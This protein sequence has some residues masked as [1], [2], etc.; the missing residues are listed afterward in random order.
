[1]HEGL[2]FEGLEVTLSGIIYIHSI[3]DDRMT[4]T[5]MKNLRMFRL[6]IGERSM[7]HCVMVTSK[8][9]IA[10]PV[11]AEQR[12]SDLVGNYWGKFLAAGA[13]I[14]RFEDSPSSAL[15]IV[16]ISLTAGEFTPQVTQEFAIQGLE[17]YRTAAGRVVNEDIAKAYEQ[18]EEDLE[19]WRREYMEALRIGDERSTAELELLSSRAEL[20]LKNLREETERLSRDR[21][22]AQNQMD[23]AIS[24][25]SDRTLAIDLVEARHRAR[26]K[27]SLRW[28][29]RFAGMGA[30]VT[31]TVLTGG[32]M[33]S[34]GV[35]LYGAIEAVCQ[36][37]KNREFRMKDLE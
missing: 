20:Q 19:K 22:L 32:A 37:D 16:K 13:H 2:T 6:L 18:H 10:G 1:M 7:E 31:M 27:R 15:D 8:W 24:S 23:D 4:G 11:E 36:A 29:A 3:C 17:L 35:S 28:F 25:L 30:A 14:A 12:E 21:E 26:Q 34:V 5:M 9:N 33:A